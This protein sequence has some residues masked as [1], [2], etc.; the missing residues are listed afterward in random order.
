MPRASS[1]RSARRMRSIHRR[2]AAGQIAPLTHGA[3]LD[4]LQAILGQMS[5]AN[6]LETLLER[7]VSCLHRLVGNTA[8]GVLRLLPGG[9]RLLCLA[10]ETTYPYDGPFT[11]PIDTGLL[12]A[13]AR[14]RQTVLANDTLADPRFISPDGWTVR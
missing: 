7:T 5:G 10:F 4:M 6:S 14:S 13:T 9:D 1:H 12:G 2:A 3:P 11:F 8:T